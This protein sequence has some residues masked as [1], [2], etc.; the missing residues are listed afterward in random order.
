MPE[1]WLLV[2]GLTAGFAVMGCRHDQGT[3]LEEVTEEWEEA[4][5]ALDAFIQERIE[6]A[7]SRRAKVEGLSAHWAELKQ[8]ELDR[9]GRLSD[10]EAAK[11]IDRQ[12]AFATM[13]LEDMPDMPPDQWDGQM[14]SIDD[15]LE[16]AERSIRNIGSG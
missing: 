5:S 2:A 11:R 15:A 7:E 1:K 10:P 3:S 4:W 12:L 6:W 9:R 13:L 14:E 8:T 16:R